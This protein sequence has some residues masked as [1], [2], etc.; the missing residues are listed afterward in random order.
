[1]LLDCGANA[2]SMIDKKL[3]HITGDGSASVIHLRTSE[4]SLKR[5]GNDLV[6]S[7]NRNF[8]HFPHL[9]ESFGVFDDL[10]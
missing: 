6:W 8:L 1:M 4:G 2:K 3:R 5:L 7:N 9:R 10:I